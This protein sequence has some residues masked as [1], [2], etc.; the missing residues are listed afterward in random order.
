MNPKRVGVIAVWLVAAVGLAACQTPY[1]D[2]KERY[3]FVAS[4]VNLPYW[5]E[6]QAGLMGAAEQKG[7]EGGVTGP[8]KV[9]SPEEARGFQKGVNNKPPGILVLVSPPET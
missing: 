8:E 7:G 1:H 2:Q 6:A 9:C 5:Q 4:N 3:V